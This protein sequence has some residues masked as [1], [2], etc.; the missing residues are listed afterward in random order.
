[1]TIP[2]NKLLSKI[3]NRY[4]QFLPT[5]KQDKAQ[6]FTSVVFTFTA[7]SIFGLFAINPTIS[8]I[9]NLRRQLDDDKYTE[10]QLALKI[11]NLS[12]LGR[13]YQEIQNDI[14][15]A[16]E[17]IPLDPQ[18]SLLAAQLQA[19]S[20]NSNI[21]LLGLQTFQVDVTTPQKTS[22]KFSS[23]AFSIATEGSYDNTMQFID[24]LSQMERVI[25]L[26]TIA[27]NK[28]TDQSGIIQLSIKG[29]A[30]FKK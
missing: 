3:Q 8:T 26:D 10:S 18:I 16:T 11:N 22:K 6:K 17:A 28:K 13:S 14:V 4:E 5:L 20:K 12:T 29:S 15:Y 21:S 27:I 9:V 19:I 30:Y 23:F 7:L 24:N 2:N 25:S 1:M